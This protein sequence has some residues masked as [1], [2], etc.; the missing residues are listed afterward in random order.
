MNGWTF[1]TVFLLLWVGTVDPIRSQV[2]CYVGVQQACLH[3]ERGYR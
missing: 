1:A 3:L 2:S